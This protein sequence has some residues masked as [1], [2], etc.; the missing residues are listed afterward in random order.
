MLDELPPASPD[1][2]NNDNSQQI[3]HDNASQVTKEIALQKSTTEVT[4]PI[5]STLSSDVEKHE[6]SRQQLNKI[7]NQYAQ[8]EIRIG[9]KRSTKYRQM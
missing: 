5:N 4:K 2:Q 3:D 1:D 9:K 8:N 7:I 6:K